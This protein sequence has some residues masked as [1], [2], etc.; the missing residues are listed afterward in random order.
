ML[1]KGG[2]EQ[3][4]QVLVDSERLK[5]L[6]LSVQSVTDALAQ[7]NINLSGGR[8]K[9]GKTEYLVRTL[10]EYNSIEEI[11]ASLIGD[12][13]GKPVRLVDV[14]DVAMGEKERDTNRA[15]QR[16]GSRVV[17]YL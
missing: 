7:Q 13:K 4:I 5:G 11:R 3:E 14:A 6:G 17:G 8:L 9:E 10:N 15:H 1:V 16:Q 2:R 12:F